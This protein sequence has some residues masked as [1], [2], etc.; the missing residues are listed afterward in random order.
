MAEKIELDV[1]LQA[2]QRDFEALSAEAKQFQSEATA[3]FNKVGAAAQKAG[4][5]TND[6]FNI[7]LAQGLADGLSDLRSE[8]KSLEQSAKVLKD[9]LKNATDPA[10]VKLYANNIAK[11]E[12]G[13]RQLDSVAKKVGVSL[14]EIPKKTTEL[15]KETA[16]GITGLK[17]KYL[18]L[19]KQLATVK[20]A[21][22]SATDKRKIIEYTAAVKV[23]NGEI[24]R[25]A[26]EAQRAGVSLKEVNKNA[27]VGKEVFGELFGQ[28]GKAALIATAITAVV[29][30]TASS[31]SLA[32]ETEKAT[33][34]IEA[35]LGSA[36][37]A[38]G[39][40]AD[41]I[42]LGKQKFIPTDDIIKAG[43]SMLGFGFAADEVTSRLAR[44]SEIS[45]GTG[46]DFNELSTLY[47]KA[48]A[49]G[50]LYAEDINQLLNAGVNIIPEFAKQLGVADDKVKKL[51]SEGKISFE[52]LEL[53][54]F[55]L[56]KQGAT[57]AGQSEAAAQTLSG[58][59]DI[60]KQNVESASRS[61]GEFLTPALTSF[62]EFANKGLS[63]LGG[64]ISGLFKTDQE[65]GIVQVGVEIFYDPV[66]GAAME[67]PIY[68][69][70]KKSTEEGIK[71]G[72]KAG[73]EA[74]QK[75]LEDAAKKARERAGKK[76]KQDAAN[77]AAKDA[78]AAEKE[79][80][81]LV[82]DAMREGEAKE[83]A[84]EN[85]RIAELKKALKK[86]RIDSSE[87][88]A[89]HQINLGEIRLKY[90]LE[91]LTA[92]NEAIQA[93]KESI[94]RGYA[95][96]EKLDL[97]K[98]ERDKLRKSKTL[99]LRELDAQIAGENF[100]A[101]VL[102]ERRVFFQKKRNDDEVDKYEKQVQKRREIFDLT[103]QAEALRR[104]L[105]FGEN[106]SEQETLLLEKRIENIVEKRDQLVAGLGE[107]QDGTDGKGSFLGKLM[108]LDDK[109]ADKVKAA[110]EQIVNSLRSV[111]QARIDAAQTDLDIA[112]EKVKTAEDQIKKEQELKDQG[113][114]NDLEARQRDL[115]DARAAQ[116]TALEEK[117]RAQRQELVIDTATQLSNTATAVT[118]IIK[119]YSKIPFVGVLLGIA[120]V[121]SL[122]AFLQSARARS[123]AI[124]TQ[125]F[126]KGGDGKVGN[127]G[128]IIGPSHEGGGV[129][130]PE[131]EGGE[132]FTSDG[133]KFAVVNKKMTS[134]HF[135]LL[136]AV[137]R[138]DRGAMR[139]YI[140]QLSTR[141]RFTHAVSDSH[142][143]P[144]SAFGGNSDITTLLEE[145]NRL[146]RENLRLNKE[147]PT[148]I[149]KG[150]R[151]EIMYPSGKTIRLRK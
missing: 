96:L 18:D 60:F 52:E 135:G 27:G 107:G 88:E 12:A 100:E 1:D 50:T 125:Q 115:A 142:S 11:L 133:K 49:Q 105:E 9:A 38:K 90:Y 134:K 32:A 2:L 36:D 119:D 150:D 46:K 42:A 62:L 146:Q 23:L 22:A 118:N 19:N 33:K 143:A 21:L 145:N 112:N 123:K 17:N 137:N 124:N 84:Q 16:D 44:I 53:A 15:A 151:V 20:S 78:A 97:E 144:H 109:D 85:Y 29:K 116:R 130:V 37:K 140:E 117:K 95:E 131:Y 122:F 106:I 58:Q 13:M 74:E 4:D 79:R 47:G 40:T 6:A 120:A 98:E 87:A 14:G 126:R 149:D 48:R 101:A 70:A 55:N 136:Q 25:T 148:I 91:R 86:Y 147:R 24:D 51:G 71:D 72:A 81:R 3:A 108:G 7:G 28:F 99:A 64:L 39:L 132:F 67:V 54:F 94:E 8:Y 75:I 41:L 69:A 31:V 10:A 77:K 68:E 66:S 128:V 26:D 45:K 129:V 113:Y 92:Q 76:A 139:K 80:Q 141:P 102:A 5:T 73:A 57:F 63:S 114:A 103:A 83:I 110:A 59:W 34:Q 56:T 43:K 30:F 61:F 127:D 121:G 35:F 89:Q 65:K 93:E 111:I 104:Q 82:L 138:D